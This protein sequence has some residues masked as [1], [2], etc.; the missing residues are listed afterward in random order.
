MSK[1]DMSVIE[2]YEKMLKNPKNRV[3]TSGKLKQPMPSS[4]EIAGVGGGKVDTSS[5]PEE[6]QRRSSGVSREEEAFI[7]ELDKRMAARQSGGSPSSS[8]S[9]LNEAS[10]KKI[11]SLEKRVKELED[12]LTEVLKIQTKLLAESFK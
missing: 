10:A 9:T 6:T 12:T 8:S 11:S 3:S 5:I 7:S 2:K 4:A 1:S